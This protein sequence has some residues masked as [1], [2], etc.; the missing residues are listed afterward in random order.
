LVNKIGAYPKLLQVV[1]LV[2]FLTSIGKNGSLMFI[3]DWFGEVVFQGDPVGKQGS[4]AKMSFDDGLRMGNLASL[5]YALV[6]S[7]FG[8]LL[9]I[10]LRVFSKRTVWICSLGV[11][12]LQ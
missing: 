12:L 10:L 11:E 5:C 2:Q 8:L 6:S 3:T 9:P 4:P 7:C 1:F